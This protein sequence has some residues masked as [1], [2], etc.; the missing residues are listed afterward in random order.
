MLTRRQILTRGTTL[1]V[2]TP[3]LAPILG[4]SSSDGDGTPDGTCAGVSTTSSV[5]VQHT[6]TLCVLT[7][8][9]T[10]PP[11]AGVTYTTSVDGSHSHRVTLT[12]AQLTSINTGQSV[13]VTSTNDPDPIANNAL[14]THT[15]TIKKA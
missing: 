14:H 12:Q 1:L 5:D 11:A 9:L 4:C 8:D 7:T 3:I 10:T 15:F 13:P 2:L 6:H